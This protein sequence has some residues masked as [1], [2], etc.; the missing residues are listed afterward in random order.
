VPA[1]QQIK[2]TDTKEKKVEAVAV[3]AEEKEKDEG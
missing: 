3:V 2:P 1:P